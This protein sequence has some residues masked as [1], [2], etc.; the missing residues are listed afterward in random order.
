MIR[1][2]LI[3]S[4][5]IAG[6]HAAAL[7]QV[8]SARLA[9][10]CGRN[11][12]TVTG[13]A[14]RYGARPVYDLDDLL[15]DDGIDA[16]LVAL[17]TH[18]HAWAV[19]RAAQAGKHVLCEKPLAL[20]LDQVDRMCAAIQ[21]AQ[22]H[23]M[24]A[25]VLRFW[26]EYHAIADLYRQGELGVPICTSA[27][28]LIETPPDLSW[29]CNP[30]E[31]G[32]ALF[33]LHVHDLDYVYS[34]YGRP[35]AVSAVGVQSATGTWD[36]V[37]T[38]LDYGAHAA[39]VEASALMPAGY[40]FTAGFR[41]L[42]SRACVEYCMRVGGQVDARQD[43]ESRLRLYRPGSQAECPLV[44]TQDA[45]VTQIA[46]LSDCLLADKSPAVGTFQDAQAV[47]EILLAVRQSLEGRGHVLL[48]S[49]EHE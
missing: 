14:R 41:L 45:Y 20:T 12:D 46:Y 31:G 4:G 6:I 25:Q 11:R 47:L 40:P 28:R 2:G 36:Q 43:A 29:F 26:P 38:S 1:F 35:R 34:L 27:M 18:L 5:F 19:I 17:P 7:A 16:V 8:E 22:V 15:A 24:V 3:G 49:V 37:V 21:T 39:V 10:V 30:E 33:D 42:G 13:L 9:A 44:A 23:A 48:D 32:G